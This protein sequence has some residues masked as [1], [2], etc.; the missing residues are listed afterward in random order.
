MVDSGATIT[1]ECPQFLK[2]INTKIVESTRQCIIT[3]A[4][5]SK[6]VKAEY[7]LALPLSDDVAP[8]YRTTALQ[9]YPRSLVLLDKVQFY[10][11]SPRPEPALF[12]SSPS[13]IDCF[14][15]PLDTSNIVSTSRLFSI[16]SSPPPSPPSH[17]DKVYR[18]VF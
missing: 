9:C 2:I 4:N 7:H 3:L 15:W 13:P 12:L 17:D 11:V 10:E 1:Y 6:S 14:T 8:L 18:Y 16:L 5:R